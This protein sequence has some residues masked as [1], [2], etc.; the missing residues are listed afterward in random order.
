[1]PYAIDLFGVYRIIGHCFDKFR[2]ALYP[3]L[4]EQPRSS[5]HARLPGQLDRVTNAELAT[6]TGRQAP[7]ISDPKPVAFVGDVRPPLAPI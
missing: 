6:D 7:S 1:M 3:N 2:N 5:Q 4:A